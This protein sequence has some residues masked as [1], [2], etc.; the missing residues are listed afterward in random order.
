MTLLDNFVLAH[1]TV[2]G[3]SLMQLAQHE[4]QVLLI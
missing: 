2:T 3:V 1:A 4:T